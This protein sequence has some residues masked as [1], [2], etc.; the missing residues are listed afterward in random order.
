MDDSFT[1]SSEELTWLKASELLETPPT[2]SSKDNDIFMQDL[3]LSRPIGSRSS[4]RSIDSASRLNLRHSSTP[5]TPHKHSSSKRTVD[6]LATPPRKTTRSTDSPCSEWIYRRPKSPNAT[7]TPRTANPSAQARPRPRPQTGIHPYRSYH[8]PTISSLSRQVSTTSTRTA[9]RT[10]PTWSEEKGLTA[11]PTESVASTSTKQFWSAILH[12]RSRS[13]RSIPLLKTI[14]SQSQLSLTRPDTPDAYLSNPCTPKRSIS[15]PRVMS[16]RPPSVSSTLSSVSS[17]PSPSSSRSES[18]VTPISISSSPYSRSAI[19]RRNTPFHRRHRSPTAESDTLISSSCP[20]PS[21]SILT[22]T[23]SVSTKDSAHTINKSV[24]FAAVP[25][26]HYASTGYWDVEMREGEDNMGINIDSMDLDDDPFANYQSHYY[27]Q[28]KDV[29]T[30][31]LAKVR[32]L[33]ER[34]LTPTPERERAKGL[35]RLMSLTRKPE[36]TIGT[37]KSVATAVKSSS[38]TA[39]SPPSSFMSKAPLTSTTRPVI[40]TPYALGS[41]PSQSTA[42]LRTAAAAGHNQRPKSPSAHSNTI[43]DDAA[44][45]APDLRLS[46][47][48]GLRTAPSMESVRSSKS[49]GARSVRSL[50]SV[51]STSSIG[52]L[53][54]WLGRTIGW[55]EP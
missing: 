54:A 44:G 15:S 25:I 46:E 11:S 29:R 16:A 14:P 5:F 19:H 10:S 28:E 13:E 36:P 43:V 22:R 6:I 7:R 18:P 23:A 12:P 38:I 50:G 2:P 4:Y 24:K 51:K 55:T 3:S 48:A 49:A 9:H 31:D 37:S 27:S 21:K 17:S 40:S 1:F 35:K 45:S 52:G 26:I 53:R 33:R 42:S 41:Y 30:L 34:Q 20:P 32:E 47:K 39:S 8:D